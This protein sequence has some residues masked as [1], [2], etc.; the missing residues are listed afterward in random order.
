VVESQTG[1]VTALDL[2]GP[3]GRLAFT[4]AVSRAERLGSEQRPTQALHLVGGQDGITISPAH[5]P[6]GR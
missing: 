2:I 6:A 4:P 3:A 1:T 5:H